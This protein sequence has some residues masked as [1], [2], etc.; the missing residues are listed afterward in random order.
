MHV[1]SEEV[2]RLILKAVD[3][4]GE[5]AHFAH[6]IN[7][8]RDSRSYV[9]GDEFF[10]GLFFKVV[11]GL[12]ELVETGQ[13]ICEE[14][15]HLEVDPEDYIAHIKAYRGPFPKWLHEKDKQYFE[16]SD[17]PPSII[18]VYRLQAR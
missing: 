14:R 15:R 4:L 7:K 12:H 17:G 16:D 18:P 6:I 9:Q 1:A 11:D 10:V 2:K 3:E 5:K 8:V 13:L